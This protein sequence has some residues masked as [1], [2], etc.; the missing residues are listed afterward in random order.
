MLLTHRT[1]ALFCFMAWLVCLPVEAAFDR[2]EL[3][4]N[5]EAKKSLARKAAP[6][7]LNR[8]N[9]GSNANRVIVLYR[10]G[11]ALPAIAGQ[12]QA[13]LASLKSLKQRVNGRMGA[14]EFRVLHDY[15]QLPMQALNLETNG[16]LAQLLV[17]PSVVAVY[18]D[19]P[20]QLHLAESLPLIHQE[21]AQTAG[22]ASAG[23][24][25]TVAVLDSG[26]DYTHAAFG[27]CTAPGLPATCKVSA[28]LDVAAND[29]ALD[30]SGH[31]TN[32]A[33]IVVGVA[34][35]A[36][37][38]ALD[39][40][41]STGIASSDVIAAINWVI[42]YRATYNIVA[43]NL[44]LGG[45][46]LASSPC[47]SYNPF[48]TPINNAKSLGIAVI[49]SSGNSASSIGIASPACTPGALAIGAVY[50]NNLGGL[51][52][53]V[54]T[55][56]TTKA[57]QI[58]CFSNSASYLFLVAPGATI[59]AAGETLSGTSQAAPHVS[60]AMAVLS[61]AFPAESL[62]A[63]E[64]RLHTSNTLITDTRNSITTPRLDLRAALGAAYTPVDE[65]PLL[66]PWGLALSML[67]LLGLGMK[68]WKAS[69]P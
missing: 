47:G 8:L 49:A 45:S 26:V 37:I 10:E 50:D 15:D 64:T 29:G 62:T 41:N 13:R 59:N 42:M 1:Y 16:S 35:S 58:T 33:A 38:V 25:S 2:A 20:L 18:N 52:W 43:I 67:L 34:P 68:R 54:C 5:P 57:D 32:V 31:G 9:T 61:S 7:F 60:G 65:I 46:A 28:A 30:S 23:L 51:N 66:P 6:N 3:E 12:K 55:D 4:R 53:G 14:G 36:K 22:I 24:G 21:A 40:M 39:V 27:S 69:A 44:S 19:E 56:Y 11:A 63:L 17:D 48:V